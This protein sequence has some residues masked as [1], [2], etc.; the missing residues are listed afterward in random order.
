M[1]QRP[2][3]KQSVSRATPSVPRG[4]LVLLA[5]FGS[6]LQQGDIAAFH[7]RL[8]RFR[9]SIRVLML[10]AAGRVL[11]KVTNERKVRPP[12]PL[13]ASA[14]TSDTYP[15]SAHHQNTQIVRSTHHR[16][17]RWL[18]LACRFSLIRPHRAPGGKQQGGHGRYGLLW[19][20]RQLICAALDRRGQRVHPLMRLRW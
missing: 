9:P 6:R 14:S 3:E 10:G 16:G 4:E 11:R 12:V 17:A 7:P 13:D 15:S 20:S 2:A 18:P 5:G 8:A 1:D 19:T